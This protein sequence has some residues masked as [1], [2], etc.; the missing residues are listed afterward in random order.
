MVQTSARSKFRRRL[1][2]LIQ[3]HSTT[4]Q[5]QA[6]RLRHAQSCSEAASYSLKWKPSIQSAKEFANAVTENGSDKDIRVEN[7][8]VSGQYDCRGDA[9][10]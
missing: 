8:H 6:E 5:V 1:R 7:D 9:V 3:S 4:G 10:P 2:S